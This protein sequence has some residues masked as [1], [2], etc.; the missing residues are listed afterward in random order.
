MFDRLSIPLVL[1]APDANRLVFSF[2]A[3]YRALMGVILLVLIAGL[4]QEGVR[5]GWPMWA[6]LAIIAL[7]VLYQEQWTFD[8]DRRRVA[9]KVGLLVAGRTLLIDFALIERFL[10]TPHVEGTIP[11]TE[12]ERDENAAAMRGG[13]GDDAGARRARHKKHYLGLVM[14]CQDGANYLVDRVPAREVAGLR[15]TAARL[16]EFCDKPLV[17]S[18]I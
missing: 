10:I 4:V 11:G 12:D 14:A 16:A 6:L 2:P 3:W 5:P 15:A 8:A 9:H 13:R 7:G 17:E 1:R 18:E